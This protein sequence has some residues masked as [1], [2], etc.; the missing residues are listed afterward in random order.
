MTERS[1]PSDE[2]GLPAISGRS[3]IALWR[4]RPSSV[5]AGKRIKDLETEEMERRA[6]ELM[7]PQLKDLG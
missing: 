1:D 3:M 4:L 2:G 5:F 6:A 7:P